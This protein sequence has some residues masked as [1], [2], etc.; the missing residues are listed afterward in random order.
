MIISE[1]N[2]LQVIEQETSVIGA[3]GKK[4][5]TYGGGSDI[6]VDIYKDVD[7]HVYEDI[8][9]YKDFYV[10]SDVYGISAFAEAEALA[11]GRNAHAESLTFTYS[12]PGFASSSA[13]S[14]SLS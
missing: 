8:Y 3:S 13:Q 7:V 12:Q 14:N 2:H 9:I 5:K 1:L 10:Y 6:D 11:Y 4:G